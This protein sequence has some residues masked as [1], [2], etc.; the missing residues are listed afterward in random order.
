MT[1]VNTF[2]AAVIHLMGAASP[3]EDIRRSAQRSLRVCVLA[4]EQMALAWMWSRRALRAVRLLAKEWLI[5]DA[6]LISSQGDEYGNVNINTSLQAPMDSGLGPGPTEGGCEGTA[7]DIKDTS[8]STSTSAYNGAPVPPSLQPSPPVPAPEYW[9][10]DVSDM[11]LEGD[12]PVH[13]QPPD[14]PICDF[15]DPTY[16]GLDDAD[17]LSNLNAVEGIGGSFDSTAQ[18]DPWVASALS[19]YSFQDPWVGIP[20]PPW[21][22]QDGL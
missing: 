22:V 7:K 14:L 6:V 9:T 21:P 2:S 18:T 10:L 8:T 12:H 19:Q 17:W 13:G 5:P 3:V 11:P 1:V 16:L 15:S 4:L 20:E